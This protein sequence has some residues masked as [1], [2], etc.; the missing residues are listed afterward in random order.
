MDEKVKYCEW[1]GK[2]LQRKPYES[3]EVF[4][5]RRYCDIKCSVQPRRNGKIK[6]VPIKSKVCF[7]GRECL[8]CPYPECRYRGKYTKEESEMG[9]CG[10]V[11]IHYRGHG[12]KEDD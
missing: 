7:P 12:K 2:V 4:S 5:R 1:C 8:E 6:P 9:A 11:D 3:D 10:H